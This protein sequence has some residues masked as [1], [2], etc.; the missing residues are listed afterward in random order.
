MNR[1]APNNAKAAEPAIKAKKADFGRKS[2]EA[3]GRHLF[4]NG[5]RGE[6][7]TGNEIAAIIVEPAA[8][9]RTKNRKSIKEPHGTV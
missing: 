9:E 7:Q 6:R 2:G 4:G 8:F 3:R 5:N 1:L